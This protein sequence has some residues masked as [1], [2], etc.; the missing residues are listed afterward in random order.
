MSSKIVV[1]AKSLFKN[2]LLRHPVKDAKGNI[3]RE[4]IALQDISFD[5]KKGESV[6]IIGPNGSGKSTL[7]KILSG[8]TKPTSGNVEIVGRVASILDIGAGFHQELTGRENIFLN[9]KILG[10]SHKEIEQQYEQII[11]FSGIGSYI[12]E[13]VKN[14]SNGMY[15]R[16]AFSI[17]AQ[18]DF[19][20][21]LF[22]EVMSVGDA[23]FIQKTR[24]KI[25]QLRTNGKTLIIISHNQVELNQC[26]YIIELEQG[27]I[28]KMGSETEI[29]SKYFL[30]SIEKSALQIAKHDTTIKDF[31][32][33]EN[34]S[35]IITLLSVKIHQPNSTD[36]GF[37]TNN[38]FIFD[39]TYQK[40]FPE[41]TISPFI[42]VS[43]A[44]GTIIFVSS[45]ILSGDV[46]DS[47][48]EGTY[49]V[50]CKVNSG[51]FSS[52]VYTLSITFVK[53]S[54]VF[55]QYSNNQ[56]LSA[57]NIK[58]IIGEYGVVASYTNIIHFRCTVIIKNFIDLG[59]LNL[60]VGLLLPRFDWTT[61]TVSKTDE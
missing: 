52:N 55:K 37:C 21:Y 7:L 12:E 24:N 14:Y 43:D 47:Q 57:A 1:S 53:N 28:K 50:S 29:L 46:S 40:H 26:N 6:G 15:L 54:H 17:L 4:H 59:K 30:E 51:F 56:E 13:P 8:V 10:F 27:K 9:G 33:Q 38:E 39:I 18:L 48:N 36:K 19:D 5:I 23:E 45:P 3:L 11:D 42:I 41:N 49:K 20:V 16:L 60:P 22:D 2:Y 58:S 35:G 32:Q 34:S 31:E 25:N 44:G 61:S